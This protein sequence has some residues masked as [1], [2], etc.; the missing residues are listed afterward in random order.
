MHGLRTSR[1]IA[2]FKPASPNALLARDVLEAYAGF[3]AVKADEGARSASR[4]REVLEKFIFCLSCCVF[5][6]QKINVSE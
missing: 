4:R 2:A 5:C 1:R 3:E 6:K